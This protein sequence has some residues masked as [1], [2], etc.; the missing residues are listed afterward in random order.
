MNA[1]RTFKKFLINFHQKF[2]Y[3]EN[4]IQFFFK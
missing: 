4:K 1:E 2:E 3:K